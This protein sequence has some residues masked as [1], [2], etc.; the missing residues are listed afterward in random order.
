[1]ATRAVSDNPLPTTPHEGRQIVENGSSCH[2]EKPIFSITTLAIGAPVVS[3]NAE[4]SS[5]DSDVVLL[6]GELLCK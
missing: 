2:Y 5:L 4:Y 1:M 6:V 3:L